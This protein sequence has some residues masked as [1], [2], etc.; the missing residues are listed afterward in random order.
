MKRFNKIFSIGIAVS[1]VL[2]CGCSRKEEVID[3]TESNL[4]YS[5]L[6][7]AIALYTDSIAAASDSASIAATSERFED[8]LTKINF[9]YLDR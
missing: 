7:A 3:R 9:K 5:E 4:L 1:S 6:K 2:L 8:K